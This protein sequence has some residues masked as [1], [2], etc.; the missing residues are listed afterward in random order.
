MPWAAQYVFERNIDA[1][2]V[3]SGFVSC[4]QLQQV[5]YIVVC[6]VLSLIGL[7]RSHLFGVC[8]LEVG[9]LMEQQRSL[10]WSIVRR[11]RGNVFCSAL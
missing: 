6:I 10:R 8:T 4:S 3:V 2:L 1:L 5:V 11:Y 9:S 7:L